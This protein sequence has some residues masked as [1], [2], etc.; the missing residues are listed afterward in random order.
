MDKHALYA[1]YGKDGRSMAYEIMKQANA[2][3]II[4]ANG[5]VAI[6]PNLV[7]SKPA[8]SGATTHPEVVMGIIDYLK[9]IGIEQIEIIESSWVGANTKM[10]FTAAGYA[11]LSLRTGVPLHDLKK[12]DSVTVQSNGLELKICKRALDADFLINVP[13]LK[14]H[15]QTYFTCALKNLKGIIPDSEKR[16]YHTLGI[17]E[18]VAKLAAVFKQ[19]MVVVDGLC[20]DLTFEEGGTPV[21]MNRVIAGVDPLLVDSYCCGLIGYAPDDIGYIRMAKELG[22]GEYYAPD[23]PLHELNKSEDKVGKLSAS[24]RASGLAKYVV[25]D[26]ACSACYGSLIHALHRLDESGGLRNLPHNSIHIGQGNR[27]KTADGIGVGACCSGYSTHVKGCPPDA[28]SI[29][30]M[31]RTQL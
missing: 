29:V 1:I 25:E 21:E 27:G 2:K 14:A 22:V 11:A 16:R 15:C 5:K 24:R 31:L 19:G 28:K 6:K 10:A 3:D 20:G 17:H 7:V 30:D 23:T 12:D 4:P 13:V 9:E 18:P 8:S 26:Q